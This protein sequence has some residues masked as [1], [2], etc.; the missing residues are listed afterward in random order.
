[1]FNDSDSFY[2]SPTG[3]LTNSIQRQYSLKIEEVAPLWTIADDRFFW[4]KYMLSDLIT[5][6]VR[7][8]ESFTMKNTIVYSLDLLTQS[9]IQVHSHYVQQ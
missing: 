3:D 8:S 9:Y 1:M 6:K 4:N 5:G 7:V 2:Y